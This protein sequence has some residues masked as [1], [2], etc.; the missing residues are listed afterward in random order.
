MSCR[1][2]MCR[3]LGG[4]MPWPEEALLHCLVGSQVETYNRQLELRKEVGV[5]GIKLREQQCV[6][7]CLKP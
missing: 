5:G 6:S 4:G 3:R 1:Q 7:W 2:P